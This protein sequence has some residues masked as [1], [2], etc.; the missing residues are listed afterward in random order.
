MTAFVLTLV[1][2]TETLLNPLH[3][4]A[5]H[6]AASICVHDQWRAPAPALLAAK[7]KKKK[8]ASRKKASAGGFGTK[9]SGFGAPPKQ[10]KR[11]LTPEQL[12]WEAFMSWVASSGGEVDAVRL[13]DCGGGLRGLRAT[14]NLAAGEVVIRIPRSIILDVARAEAC[15]VSG[16]WKEHAQP[17]PGYAKIALAVLYEQR[18]GAESDLAPYL[19]L[20]PS[21]DEFRRD[22]GPAATWTDEELAVTECG[23]LIDAA[24]RRRKQ[25]YGDGHPALRTDALAARWRQLELPGVAPSAEELSWATTVVTSRA[26]GVGSP[27]EGGPPES[28]LIPMVDMANHVST[29]TAIHPLCPTLSCAPCGIIRDSRLLRA[30]TAF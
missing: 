5:N 19:E 28:G 21:A 18:R 26:Y 23:K 7:A 20:L 30:L 25:S 11:E 12:Q 29:C 1:V 4:W 13:A 17:L 8:A 2:A 14:R 3:S 22:G 10:A 24:K 6:R 15:A 16:V 27:S 9:A